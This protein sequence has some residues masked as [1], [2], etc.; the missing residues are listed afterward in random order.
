MVMLDIR[1]SLDERLEAVD[2]LIP[3]PRVVQRLA[4]KYVEDIEAFLTAE[5]IKLDMRIRY[6]AAAAQRAGRETWE[7][8]HRWAYAFWAEYEEINRR[9]IPIDPVYSKV[10]TGT[11]ASATLSTYDMKAAAAGQTRILESFIG[12]EATSAAVLRMFLGFSAV[13]TGTAP[14]VYVPEK[15]NTR[16]P[17]A[18]GVVYGGLSANADWGTTENTLNA[19]PVVVHAFNAFGGTDRWVAPPGGEIYLVNAEY[20]SLRSL[21]GTSTISQ[22]NIFEEL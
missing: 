4:R 11:A 9:Y 19:N 6:R 15:F 22:H 21:S 5:R 10:T 2:A 3:E 7:E 12:G 14:T 17:A 16:S 20:A 13:G 18:A 1:R 8:G